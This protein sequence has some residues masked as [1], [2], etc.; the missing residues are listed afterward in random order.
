MNQFIRKRMLK[1]TGWLIL[2]GLGVLWWR[3]GGYVLSST[4]VMSSVRGNVVGN[5]RSARHGSTFQEIHVFTDGRTTVVEFSSNG[6]R[7]L[8]QFS[9]HQDT[10]NNSTT[11]RS[12]CQTPPPPASFFEQSAYVVA[13]RCTSVTDLRT[14]TVAPGQVPLWYRELLAKAYP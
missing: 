4:D 8:E 6:G 10:Q 14:F 1:I 3:Y 9:K 7:V 2:L 11:L 13:I 5:I 12:W